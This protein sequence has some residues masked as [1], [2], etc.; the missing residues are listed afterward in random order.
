VI[1]M[2]PQPL[3]AHPQENHNLHRP[4]AAKHQAVIPY[5]N[6]LAGNCASMK[7]RA[8]PAM[9]DTAPASMQT[10]A[11]PPH[12]CGGEKH[13]RALSMQQGLTRFPTHEKPP[14]DSPGTTEK[15]RVRLMT[16][17]LPPCTHAAGSQAASTCCTRHSC[18]P[19]SRHQ[20]M[21]THTQH[22][23]HRRTQHGNN[24]SIQV[25]WRP[26]VIPF[27]I[28]AGSM[29]CMAISG[30]PPAKAAHRPKPQPAKKSTDAVQTATQQG[31]QS[32]TLHAAPAAPKEVCVSP[33]SQLSC[34]PTDSPPPLLTPPP[35][36][37]DTTDT[38]LPTTADLAPLYA[39]CRRPR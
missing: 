1:Q 37:R 10:I 7:R 30:E 28:G 26:S 9:P 34:Q 6:A 5:T 22:E 13:A 18:R 36:K 12:I 33:L 31:A 39:S 2:T 21:H 11:A 19:A 25:R 24:A 23:T 20:R 38:P 4:L 14:R 29:Q 32:Q 27:R 8:I 3:K 15:N 16:P 35:Q 17:P